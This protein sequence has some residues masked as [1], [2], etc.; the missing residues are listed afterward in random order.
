MTRWKE[1]TSSINLVFNKLI[2]GG[3]RI[4][5]SD[6]LVMQA[7][8][9]YTHKEVQEVAHLISGNWDPYTTTFAALIHE[10]EVVVDD[11]KPYPFFLAYP[12]EGGVE[13]LG[14]PDEWQVEW[15]WDGIGGN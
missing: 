7:L 15:K 3:F 13:K 5:V 6:N 9:A 1:Q 4:G 8:A 14:V 12:V 11:S 10:S 2:T